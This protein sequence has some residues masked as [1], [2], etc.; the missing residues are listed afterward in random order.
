[1]SCLW[2]QRGGLRGGPRHVG[3]GVAVGLFLMLAG[4][5]AHTMDSP[6]GLRLELQRQ[7]DLPLEVRVPHMDSARAQL[8]HARRLKTRSFRGKGHED[9]QFWRFLAIEAYQAV[10][11]YHPGELGFSAEAAFR[12]GELLRADGDI[13]AA[14]QEFR[15]AL[16]LGADT[17]FR[18]RARLELGHL[19]RRLGDLRQALDQ[20]LALASDSSALARRREDAWLWAGRCWW[21]RGAHVEARRAWS[22]VAERALDPFLALRAHDELALAWLEEGDLK[23]A[24]AQI[25]RCGFDLTSVLLEESERGEKLSNAF[26]RMRARDALRSALART[27]TMAA[28]QESIQAP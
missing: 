6:N 10:R 12:A 7:E 25:E 8:A 13:K 26:R 23:A 5:D 15:L 11:E 18:A 16:K 19:A 3:L 2:R 22:G 9:R 24:A 21:Q 27:Q 28:E 4:V 1:M 14:R 17:P 20:Y